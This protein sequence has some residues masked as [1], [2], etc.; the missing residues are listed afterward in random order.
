[1]TSEVPCDGILSTR[2]DDDRTDVKVSDSLGVAVRGRRKGTQHQNGGMVASEGKWKTRGSKFTKSPSCRPRGKK[3][4]S[5][6]DSAAKGPVGKF[7]ST[8]CKTSVH[9]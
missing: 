7:Q 9:S 8:F 5:L 4:I 1:M 3:A 2:S 6:E